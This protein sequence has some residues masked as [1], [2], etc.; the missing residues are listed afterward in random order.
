M[1][2]TYGH[3]DGVE[4][5][6]I[7]PDRSALS[8][9]GVHGPPVAGIWGGKDGAESIVLNEGYIDDEDFGDQIIYTGH[10]GN[11]DQRQ[12]ADQEYHKGNLGLAVS[13]IKG[14]SVRVSR[15]PK[16]KGPYGCKNGYRYDGL[17][18]VDDYWQEIG[19]DG[20]KIWRYRLV[21]EDSIIR[22][23]ESKN[24]LGTPRGNQNPKR[25][26]AEVLRIVRDTKLSKSVK[27]DHKDTC[28]SCSIQLQVPGGT[29]SEAA[30][31]KPLGSPHN[32]PDTAE[33]IICLCPNCHVLFDRGSIWLDE[34]HTWQP[35]GRPLLNDQ[36]NPLDPQNSEYHRTRF[37]SR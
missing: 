31:V 35:S 7:F 3:I 26:K 22:D 5:G 20:F 14:Y 37:G 29:Y 27:D 2:R 10:G 21:I 33:N 30:H 9:A 11:K 6:D 18:R 32:G 19:K 25:S 34:S 1:A 16:L 4:I 36:I 24:P 12:V 13:C 8:K 15:G 23:A 28:Q 17:Y